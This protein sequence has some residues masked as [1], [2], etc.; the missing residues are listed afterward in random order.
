[1]SSL[2]KEDMSVWF[3]GIEDPRIE[4][5]K[6]YPITEII[7]LCIFAALHSIES[8]RGTELLGNEKLDFLRRFFPFKNGIPSHQTLGRV[9]SLLKP[10]SFESFF[11]SW[12]GTLS[13]SNAGKQIAFDGKALRGSF[14]KAS[15]KKAL[16]ILNACAV[17]NGL[18][19]AQLEVDSKTN[20]ITTLPEMIDSL[21]IA[22]AMVSVDAL[23]TQKEIAAK[24]INA[25]A[26]YT[27]ALKG[28]HKNL[29]EEAQY[30]F[31]S[32]KVDSSPDLDLHAESVDKGH[33]RITERQFDIINVDPLNLPQTPDWKGLKA[34]G[35]VETTT[36]RDGKETFETRFYLLSYNSAKLFAKSAQ[37]H[38]AIE[39][40]LHWTLDVTFGEDASRKRKDHAPRNFSLIRKFALN[41]LR[42]FKGK[43]SV[44]L[45]QIKAAANSEYLQEILIGAGFKMELST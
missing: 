34:I 36:L 1:M 28:N 18:A 30:L 4:R 39:N 5:S 11:M 17:D 35:R 38:W 31:N 8:W 22:G 10:K 24:I 21:D 9:F 19:L 20:E 40:L 43:L 23:N 16:H 32:Q 25:K 7:F 14:D 44:P 3:D 42:Q 45:A 37:G 27:L 26:D 6:K 29:T 15:G 2:I 41:V 13:G 12:A 33:G